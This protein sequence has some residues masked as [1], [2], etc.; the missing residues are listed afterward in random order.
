MHPAFFVAVAAL[1]TFIVTMTIISSVCSLV[2]GWS[3][4]AKSYPCE[5]YVVGTT[6]RWQSA[7]LRKGM[8]YNGCLTVT[9]NAEGMRV[10]MW[11]LMRLGHPPLFFPWSDVSLSRQ[12]DWFRSEYVRF[13]L[14]REPALPFVITG[15]LAKKIQ[16]AIG[17]AWPEEA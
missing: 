11:P 15:R 3:K 9:A 16:E 14:A 1:V 7:K 8:N 13:T 10:S 6:W 2:S 17:P 5:T 4:L 12:R